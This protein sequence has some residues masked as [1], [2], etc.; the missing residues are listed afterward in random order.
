MVQRFWPPECHPPCGVPW[1]AATVRYYK[2]HG[3]LLWSTTGD[4]VVDNDD[5]DDDDDQPTSPYLWGRP[6]SR[7]TGPYTYDHI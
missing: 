4:V 7:V 3:V 2:Y 1:A 6:L 5:D